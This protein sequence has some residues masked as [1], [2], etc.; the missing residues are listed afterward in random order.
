MAEKKEYVKLWLSYRS[1]FEPYSAAEVGRL[2]LAMMDYRASGV[3]PE[4]TGSERFVW[5]AIRR[6]LDESLKAQE[7]SAAANRENGKKGGRPPKQEKPIGFSENP[8]NPLGFSE[9]EKTQG[10]RTKDKGQGQGQ[11][12]GQ[13]ENRACARDPALA[14]VIGAYRNLI[15]A[16][17][18]PSSMDELRGYVARMGPECCIKAIDAA[19]DAGARSW[20]YVRAILQSRESQGVKSLEDWQRV[21]EERDRRKRAAQPVKKGQVTSTDPSKFRSDLEWMDRFLEETE[22][23]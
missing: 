19:A 8:K 6:D 20:S 2:V 13:G 14:A 16:T 17:P 1:Y 4:F 18:S 11:G 3:E 15:S 23:R 10:Q 5:P 21:D 12:Q 9:S 7:A 22:G